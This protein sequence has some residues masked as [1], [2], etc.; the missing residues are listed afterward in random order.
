MEE[1]LSEHQVQADVRS[2]KTQFQSPLLYSKGSISTQMDSPEKR[3]YTLSF[4]P[5]PPTVHSP[6]SLFNSRFS[7]RE[8]LPY[9]YRNASPDKADDWECLFVEEG[10]I[11]LFDPSFGKPTAAQDF[12]ETNSNQLRPKLQW[13]AYCRGDNS[14]AI[15]YEPSSKTFFSS[16]GIF[17]AG[18]F[19]GCFLA[20]YYIDSCKQ[21]VRLCAKCRHVL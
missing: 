15:K 19:L 12:E 4:S 21:P 2:I 16:L 6:D 14:T 18:G 20:P 17:L 13:C 11:Q 8:E 1:D 9:S 5:E 3:R 7:L 10:E